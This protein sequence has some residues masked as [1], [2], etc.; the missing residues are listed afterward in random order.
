MKLFGRINKAQVSSFGLFF[1]CNLLAFILYFNFLKEQIRI[2]ASNFLVGLVVYVL[3]YLLFF[4]FAKVVTYLF[5]KDLS[6]K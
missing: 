6:K 5:K 1:I 3:I 2:L 4:Y